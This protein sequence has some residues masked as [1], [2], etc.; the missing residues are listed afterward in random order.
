MLLGVAAACGADAAPRA[1]ADSAERHEEADDTGTDAVE[2]AAPDVGDSDHTWDGADGDAGTGTEEDGGD[3][4]DVEAAEPFVE[5][6]VAEGETLW[7]IA[8]AY[9][10][11]VERIMRANGLRTR[12]ITKL[13]K[14]RILR[15]PGATAVATV[16]TQAERAAAA[17]RARASLPPIDDGA[18]HFVGRGETLWSIA[19][20]YGKTVGEIA[21]RNGFTDDDLRSLPVGRPVIVPGIAAD[22]VR[23]AESRRPTGTTHALA[24]G[25]TVWDLARTYGVSVGEIMSANGMTPEA[26]RGLREGD[27]LFLPGVGEGGGSRGIRR[28]QRGPQ[29]AS[30]LARRLGLGTREAAHDLLRGRVR[31]A[32]LQAA[33]GAAALPGTLRWPVGNGWYTRGY[34]SGED[35][36]HLAVD[37]MGEIGW[38]V[39]AAAAGLVGYSGDGLTGYG[40]TVLIIHP[41]GWVTMYAHN[42]VNFVAAGQRV[43]AGAIVAELGSTGISRGPHV[44]FELIFKGRNCDPQHLFRPGV[45][46]RNGR[47]IPVGA[48]VW[49]DPDEQPSSVRC[50]PRRRH[51]R[52]RWV[53]GENPEADAAGTSRGDAEAQRADVP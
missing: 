39:R 26:V 6:E 23:Q 43:S 45:R 19:R 50:A 53:V 25:E 20:S 44:H 1:P 40:N 4:G 33:G 22:Q 29:A 10:V 12:H 34:G 36:Y 27:R 46:H 18:Y 5:H 32:W 13:S 8:L 47:F 2:E 30:T 35:G 17:E 24:R 3:A 28:P 51:P 49:T 21:E 38:N 48:A 52:S 31:K 11:G 9:G 14:G 15:I 41:G 42:S 7:E 37:I 16:L